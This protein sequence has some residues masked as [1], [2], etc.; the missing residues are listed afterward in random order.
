[1]KL[2]IQFHL[3]QKLRI[4]GGVIY[5]HSPIRLYGVVFNQAVD[6]LHCVVKNS[7]SNGNEQ[8]LL[9]F[10][11]YCASCMS[12]M[13]RRTDG[14]TDGHIYLSNGYHRLLPWG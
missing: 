9:N 5:L 12:E 13:R 10:Q 1:M 2:T 3:M 11:K 8:I 4:C 6:R 14:R 7:S